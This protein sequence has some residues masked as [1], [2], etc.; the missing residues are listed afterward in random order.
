MRSRSETFLTVGVRLGFAWLA[1]FGVVAAQASPT[2]GKSEQRRPARVEIQQD[3]SG[4]TITQPLRIKEEVRSD[5]AEAM[6]CYQRSLELAPGNADTL[7]NIALADLLFGHLKR[8]FAGYEVRYHPR[9][10]NKSAPR[11]PAWGT[12]AWIGE[13]VI[14]RAG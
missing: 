2:A 6:R 14:A 3:A 9:S 10:Q 4:L 1:A 11:P 12:G 8:G 7:Y 13:N 5:Y